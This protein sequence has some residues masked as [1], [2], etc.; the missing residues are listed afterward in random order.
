M[1]KTVGELL[2]RLRAEGLESV[3]A[4]KSALRKLGEA[5]ASSD[6]RLLEL[7]KDILEVAR[8]G[9][10]SRQSIK[11][12]IDAL[13]GLRDQA[14]LGG[15]AFK[16]FS[17]DVAEYEAKLKAVDAQIDS[18]GKK[19]ATLRQLETQFTGRTVEGV[20]KQIAS[21]KKLLDTLKP[22]TAEY[23]KQ[24]GGIN[25]LEQGVSRALAR[26]Q[27]IASAQMQATVRFARGGDVTGGP[28]TFASALT[29]G[30]GPLPQTI[31]ALNLEIGELKTELR[32]LDFTS[33][34]YSQTQARIL[35]LEEELKKVTDAR[36]QSVIDQEKRLKKLDETEE[37][38]ARRAAK[39]AGIQAALSGRRGDTLE[40]GSRDPKTGAIIAEG[41]APLMPY[42]PP[43]VR[44]ISDLYRS[45]GDIGMAGIS[46]DIDRMGKSY[47]EVARDIQEATLASNGSINSL[48]AQRAS[49]AS[50][51]AGLDPTSKEYKKVGREIEKIDRQLEKLNK[52]RRRP[53][54][55]GAASILGG[56]AAGGV[57]GGPEGA[58][59]GA[60]GGAVGGVAGVAAGAAIGAQVKMLREALGATASYA[61]ELQKLEIALE[62]VTEV[63]D[64]FGNKDVISS[65]GN[66]QAGLKAASDVTRD[67]NIPLD[68]STKGITRLAAAVIGAGGNI[69]DAE[70]VFR[71]ITSA[72]K[73]TGGGAQDVDSAIT[74]MVQT[75][76]KGKVSAEE[77]SGQLGERLPGAVTKFAKANNMTLPELQKAFKAG[78]VGLDELMKFVVSL[79]PEYEETAR[80]IA[81]S[82]AD[83]GAKAAVAFQQVRREI[84]EALQ[85]I[86]GELQKA[87]ADFTLSILPAIKGAATGAGTALKGLMNILAGLVAN[88]KEILIVAG[89]AGAVGAFLKLTKIVA[90]LKVAV[91]DLKL[92]F[93]VL[94]KTMLFNPFIALAAGITA[95]TIALIKHTKKNEEFN[96]S[97]IS[98]N[99]SNEEAN[100]KLRDLND[101]V[102]EL[103]QRLEKETNNRMIK[104]LKKQLD[105]ARIAAGNLEL[106]MRLAS[107]YTVAGVEYNRMEGTPI[108]PPASTSVSDFPDAD[109][110]GSESA[111][112][113]MTQVE[114]DLRDRIRQA[115]L[116]E[117]KFLEASLTYEL[118]I[119]TAN[120]ETED[121]IARTNAIQQA[122]VDLILKGRDLRKQQADQAAREAEEKARTADRIEQARVLAGEIT[123]EEYER[124]KILKEMEVLLKDMPELLDKIKEKLKEAGTPLQSFRD[125]LE[126]V[127]KEAMNVN[128]ALADAGVQAVQKFGDAFADFVATGKASFA[129]LTRS[130]LQDLSRIF[131]R[132]ALFKALSFIPGVGNFLSLP[133]FADGGVIA[134]NKIVPFAYGGIV[135]K[136]TIFPMANGAGLV[137][138]AGPEAIMPLRRGRNGKLGVEASGGVGNVVVN[139]D[140][141]GSRVQGD[142]PNAKA[143]GSAIGVAVQAELIK[144]KRPGGLLS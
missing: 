76:S 141:S 92:A 87:F 57:F 63:Q 86:G 112:V 104:A 132:A 135:N 38:R 45:I 35:E 46:A 126:K 62:G 124:A 18:T 54:F 103:E 121:A 19:I 4:L 22:L 110:G 50:L 98:G 111:R 51:R 78:T 70:I 55:A 15:E 101:K 66:Y 144:Q 134:K 130:I 20:E 143:L 29:E 73:A 56:I 117:N 32:D 53:T 133:G 138:E 34:D 140:A 120:K 115:R 105:A 12:Q 21:R 100:D 136:P 96:K 90:A 7:K 67:F 5:S 68:V 88:L 25:A 81:D 3:T 40:I 123:Q 65:L 27:V 116:E 31:N 128:Q 58:V 85:P 99:T 17:K 102:A 43:Q 129:D 49:W 118:D 122:G 64:K 83:S 59:G 95:A 137:G 13:K 139:V 97:V 72:I 80:Q 109:G 107:S 91:F 23:A 125:G 119:L 16:Q 9:K 114:L 108:N 93:A 94:T 106:A 71:N 26:Q 6:K 1:A 30:L 77:L 60:I 131:A 28:G 75:F 89:V 142:Q 36:T 61:A 11:G 74:A 42:V 44:E 47:Q 113:M 8:A 33:E 127:F 52:R 79:G 24:L 69:T 41:T 84:G 82:S 39:V 2:V 10:S 14:T 37:R 48:Q